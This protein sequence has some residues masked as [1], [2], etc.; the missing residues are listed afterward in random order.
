MSGSS[1]GLS[2]H[3]VSDVD[4][5]RERTRGFSEAKSII[6]PGDDNVLNSVFMNSAI[7]RDGYIF[8]F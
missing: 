3:M 1:P 7:F 8:S 6:I 5:R 2:M 4:P